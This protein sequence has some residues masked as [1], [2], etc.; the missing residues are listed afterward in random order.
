MLFRSSAMHLNQRS[1]PHRWHIHFSCK[2]R[3][4]VLAPGSEL[5]AYERMYSNR[6]VLATYFRIEFGAPGQRIS[7]GGGHS[8]R[9]SA[10]SS[11]SA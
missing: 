10:P 8:S 2:P 3:V 4:G 7:L 11:V 6:L 1:P 9:F 5:P